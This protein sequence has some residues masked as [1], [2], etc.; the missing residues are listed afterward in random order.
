VKVAS[1]ARFGVG[2][3]A[4]AAAVALGACGEPPVSKSPG[5]P[6]PPSATVSSAGQARPDK[7][8]DPA[9]APAA[10]SASPS[11]LTPKAK[12]PFPPPDF[13]PPSEKSAQPGDGKWTPLGDPAAGDRA[14]EPP[15]V[16]YRAIVHPHRVSKYVS[17]TVVA[18][19]LERAALHLVAGTEEPVTLAVTKQERTGLVPADHQPG[20]VAVFNGGY[21][22][23]HGGW[24]MMLDGKVYVVPR[25]PGC[26]LALYKDGSVR[27]QSWPGLSG[28]QPQM[29]AFRQTPPCLVEDGELHADLQAK[30]E[31]AWGGR[32][33][34][35]K[36]RHRSAVGVD[37]TGR[38]LFYGLGEEAG[39]VLLAEGMR[40]AG[41][42]GAAQLDINYYWTRFLLYGK[43]NESAELDVTS[44]LIPQMQRPRRGYV[45][46]PE[47]RDFFYVRRR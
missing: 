15:H 47:L 25:D 7:G 46:K 3:R 30:R 13:V 33:P 17:V 19:D 6:R 23:A 37:R 35:I 42:V 41:A 22:T 20:L 14:A 10:A 36:T 39:P 4:A 12:T 2:S 9:R 34:N 29:A 16:L 44:S 28:T 45:S 1:S 31:A 26:T 18:I 27:I 21:K 11:E 32:V 38:V 24:G 40:A 43:K 8:L 5:D